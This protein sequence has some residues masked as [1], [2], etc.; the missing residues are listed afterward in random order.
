MLSLA[1]LTYALSLSS[2]VRGQA[3][4]PT[5]G[6]IDATCK[7]IA[8]TISNASE[9]FFPRMCPSLLAPY[10]MLTQ[11]KHL[12]P[13]SAQDIGAISI[14]QLRIIGS[15]RI[16]FAV[17]SGGHASN[18]GF[19]S[20]TGIQ[21][22]M[23]RFRNITV[24]START[25]E[26]GP[27]LTWDEV[28]TE[29]ESAGVVVIGGRIQVLALRACYSALFGLGIDNIVGI[30]VV[31]PNGTFTTVTSK[32]EDL[33]F[34]LRGGMNNFGIVTK[35]TLKSFSQGQVWAGTLVYSPDQLD[36]FNQAFSKVAQNNDTKAALVGEFAYTSEAVSPGVVVFYDAPTP[37]AGLFDDLLSIP[38]VSNDVST[39]SFADFVL[40][41]N[42]TN[43]PP[44]LRGFYSGVS[45]T[46]YTPAILNVLANETLFWGNKL[47]P[48][49]TNVSIVA[50]LEP[51]NS[52]VFSHGSDSAFPPDRSRALFPSVINFVWSNASLDNTMAQSL[53]ESTDAAH[54]AALA[55]GQNVSDASPYINYALFD[56]PVEL[57]YGENLPRLQAIKK[58][59]DPEDVMGLAV[60]A[61][62]TVLIRNAFSPLPRM[63]KI[64]STRVRC[65]FGTGAARIVPSRLLAPLR[66]LHGAGNNSKYPV[67]R[68]PAHVRYILPQ[69]RPRRGASR[70][71]RIRVPRLARWHPV[72]A[73]LGR[74]AAH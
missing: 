49:D 28:Y 3:T 60:I 62:L 74:C 25:V 64:A 4:T 10:M 40:S 43:P 31:L 30:E 16:P 69:R 72:P 11:S 47:T 56:T 38:T 29:L 48:L 8:A 6:G 19:S 39:R 53:R 66:V 44:I 23:A 33:W 46:E 70:A 67:S 24:N 27:G 14:P 52:G 37:P 65:V 42:S 55:E 45:L 71:A 18:P 36:A 35:F 59:I 41:T 63:S 13:G 61:S 54:A 15:T 7:Q 12:Q 20:T 57:L 21:I 17:K 32:D 58:E 1:L 34:A 2:A 5:N 68:V 22:S 9:V 73:T 51:F 26:V 50:A